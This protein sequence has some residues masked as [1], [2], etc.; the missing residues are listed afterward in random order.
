MIEAVDA[1]GPVTVYYTRDGSLP[2]SGSASFTGHGQFE[3]TEAGNHVIACYA[4]DSDGNEHYQAFPYTL[5][6]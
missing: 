6:G 4:T 1:D 2:P 3:L 5:A